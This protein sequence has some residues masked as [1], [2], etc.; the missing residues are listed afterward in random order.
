[1]SQMHWLLRIASK[2]GLVGDALPEIPPG[3]PTGEVWSVVG[4]TFSVPPARLSELVAEG[5]ASAPGLVETGDSVSLPAGGAALFGRSA[6]AAG[7]AGSA[8]ALAAKVSDPAIVSAT[9][10]ATR[11]V[12]PA[13]SCTPILCPKAPI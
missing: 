6:S 2:A 3:T 10:E 11:A 13:R 9:S 8:L 5:R 4:R 1:M 7:S 12:R